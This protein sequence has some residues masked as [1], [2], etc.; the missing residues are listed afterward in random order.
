MAKI[1]IAG[2]AFELAP[3]KLGALRRAAPHIDAV[4]AIAGALSTLEGALEAGR[5]FIEV[6]AIAI[7]KIDPAMTADAIEEM[8]G[9][10]EIPALQEGFRKLLAESG[11]APK[12]EAQAPS[13]QP[14]EGAASPGKL[15]KS[16][17]S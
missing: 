13:A 12:G 2:R 17:A 5:H 4:N 7:E 8:L 3:L 10:E 9:I 1:E 16:S 11:L 15:A 6:L 14:K